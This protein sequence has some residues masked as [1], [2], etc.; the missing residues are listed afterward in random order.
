MILVTGTVRLPE[1]GFDKLLPAAKIMMTETRQEDGCV[2]YAYARDLNDPD[3]MH[4]SE[5]WRDRE[6]LTAH[7]ETPHMKVWRAAI[8]EVGLISR[9]LKAYSADEG[10]PI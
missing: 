7:F 6:A 9:D 3:L 5:T 8:A 2:T 10:E 4:V 1:G